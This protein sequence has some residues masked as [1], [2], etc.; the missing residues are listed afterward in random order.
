[1]SGKGCGLAGL[2][3]CDEDVLWPL[4]PRDMFAMPVEGDA[5]LAGTRLGGTRPGDDDLAGSS[6]AGCCSLAA[7]VEDV[8]EE[9]EAVFGV[10]EGRGDAS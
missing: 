2:G 3:H 4:L 5:D 10:V 8:I 9:E 7:L 6:C 1:M